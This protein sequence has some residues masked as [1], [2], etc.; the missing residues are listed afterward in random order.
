MD[1]ETHPGLK[2]ETVFVLAEWKLHEG[3]D[4]QFFPEHVLRKYPKDMQ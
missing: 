2:S 4:C 3:S 1:L